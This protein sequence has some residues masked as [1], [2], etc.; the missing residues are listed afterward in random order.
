M[1]SL[2]SSITARIPAR[3]AAAFAAALSLSIAA[4]AQNATTDEQ[5]AARANEAV[6]ER[7]MT[8][9]QTELTGKV[10]TRNAAVG[11]E[12][13]ARTRDAATLADGTA[14]PKGTKLV[15]HVIQV[16]AQSK[17]QPVA[18]LAI[19]FDRAQLKDGSSVALRSMIRAVAPASNRSAANPFA[20]SGP[21]RGGVPMGAGPVGAGPMDSDPLGTDPMG[22]GGMSGGP[23]ASAG[24]PVGGGTTGTRGGGGLGDGQ[25]GLGGSLPG[26]TTR[27]IGQRTGM[28]PDMTPATGGG[29]MP[30]TKAGETTSTAPRATALPGVMLSN[31]AGAGVSGV[32]MASGQNIS[33]GTGTQITLGVISNQPR[34]AP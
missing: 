18:M 21:V 4:V 31:S 29:T 27:P 17:D 2:E 12:V 19:T 1:R 20:A 23:V 3:A 22:G 24:G 11:Q 30:V 13:T 15:G 7:Y 25:G 6:V 28:T 9:V 8:N 33:L 34:P 26:Q 32:L 10:D 14:L 16:A 5:A